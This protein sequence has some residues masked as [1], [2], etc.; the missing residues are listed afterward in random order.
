MQM[1]RIFSVVLGTALVLGP[2]AGAWAQALVNGRI[3]YIEPVSRTLYFS[4]GRIVTL[5][6]G[7]TLWVDGREL[8]LETLRRG[9]TVSV[10]GV[11]PR[12]G[13]PSAMTREALVERGN[14]V[15][16]DEVHIFRRHQAP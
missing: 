15:Q 8:P 7:A 5:E 6:P 12:S 3:E 11:A 16:V 10:D 14:V 1:L 13:Q 4:D 2:S 9:M